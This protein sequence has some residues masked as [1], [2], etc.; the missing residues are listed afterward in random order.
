MPT[1]W[2]SIS[3]HINS[4]NC[5]QAPDCKVTVCMPF[6]PSQ[7]FGLCWTVDVEPC[8]SRSLSIRWL[9]TKETWLQS[10]WEAPYSIPFITP[11]PASRQTI[12]ATLIYCQWRYYCFS[13]SPYV[14]VPTEIYARF[15]EYDYWTFRVSLLAPR[16]HV[17]CHTAF[18]WTACLVLRDLSIKY[19]SSAGY[20]LMSSNIFCSLLYTAFSHLETGHCMSG[21]SKQFNSTSIASAVS[22]TIWER[23]FLKVAN[24]VIAASIYTDLC[25]LWGGE[26][27]EHAQSE[28]QTRL[29]I[30]WWVERNNRS[31]I[32]MEWIF[33]S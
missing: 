26:T 1:N 10:W 19:M 27:Q 28:Q 17:C 13:L 20:R 22:S 25:L 5:E 18:Y 15:C 4:V 31:H 3:E 2:T 24:C 30:V 6:L 21:S 7:Y 11:V 14:R 8:S 33:V 29:S 32:Y 12:L 9:W 23:S 16:E